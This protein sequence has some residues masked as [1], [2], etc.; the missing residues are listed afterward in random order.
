M[1][2]FGKPKSLYNAFLCYFYLLVKVYLAS[3]GF[4]GNTD[5]IG[6]VGQ[7]FGVF[8]KLM[9]GCQENAAALPALQKLP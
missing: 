9:D 5:D 7:K 3:V 4:I 8:G 1:Q 2:V 6:S